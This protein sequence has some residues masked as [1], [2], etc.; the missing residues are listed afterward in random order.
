MSFNFERTRCITL[1]IKQRF[2]DL[3]IVWGSIHPTFDPQ[4]SMQYADFFC[5]GEGENAT[6]ELVQAIEAGSETQHIPQYLEQTGRAGLPE[7]C[8]ASDSK[9]G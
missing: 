1:A 8:P 5:V 7:R 3:P 6:L 2:P 9:P 4:G